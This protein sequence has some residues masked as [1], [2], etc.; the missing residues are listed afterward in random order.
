ML[1]EVY[2]LRCGPGGLLAYRREADYLA[3][4]ETPDAAAGRVIP[5]PA[6]Q[7]GSSVAVLHS[8]SWRHLD[9]GTIVLSY[10][11][12]PDPEPGRR[13]VPITDFE[14]AS[15]GDPRRP[16]PAGVRHDQ[17][18]AHAARHLALLVGTDPVV[19]RALDAIPG[20]SRALEPLAPAPAGGLAHG[21]EG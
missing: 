6:A 10:A 16:S 1:V 19:R 21:D 7:A 11:A 17:V 8:T 18:A 13:A 14:M 20:L 15:S 4:G 5:G 12:V 9:D 3:A 2:L